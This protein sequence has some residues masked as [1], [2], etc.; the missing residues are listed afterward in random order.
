MTAT[1]RRSSLPTT[2]AGTSVPSVKVDV[3]LLGASDDVRVRD[4]VPFLVDDEPGTGADGNERIVVGLVDLLVVVRVSRARRRR[5]ISLPSMPSDRMFANA[6]DLARQP[7]DA[8]EA[9]AARPH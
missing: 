2:V 6:G 1:S 7:F 5:Q 3:Q 8:G 9:A 4:D